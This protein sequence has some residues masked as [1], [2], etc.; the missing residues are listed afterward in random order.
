MSETAPE[1]ELP[2]EATPP[3]PV[4]PPKTPAISRAAWRLVAFIL[5]GALVLVVALVATAP[6]WAPFLPWSQPANRHG[7]QELAARL[8]KLAAAQDETQLQV[9]QAADA[10]NAAAQRGQETQAAAEAA[11]QR[12]DRRVGTLE[13]R[14]AVS[15]D[16]IAGL[17][18]QLSNLVSA[19]SALGSRLDAVEKTLRGAA[20]QN[21]TE[22]AL[23]LAL[24]QIREAVAAGRPFAAEF[25]TLEKL[26]HDRPDVAQAAAPLADPAKSGVATD[27]VLAEGLRGLNTAVASSTPA[28]KP[29]NWRQQMLGELAGLVT[30]RRVGENGA[31]AGGPQAA[32]HAAEASLAAGSLADAV[33]AIEKL[34][35]PAAETAAP[36]LQMAK[37]RLAVDVA[38][39]QLET[40]LTARLGEPAAAPKPPG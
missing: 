2:P 6:F 3:A 4:P 25:E 37:R 39:R 35:G 33:A 11:L 16:D 29:K 40:L 34:D 1:A 19:Q 31:P 10:A 38:L 30:I 23:P 17:G 20:A 36:W 12:L 32:V 28:A 22:A 5:A 27:A 26:A 8:D 15:A 7:E 21:T 14:P 13:Q 24:L 18:K 9:K